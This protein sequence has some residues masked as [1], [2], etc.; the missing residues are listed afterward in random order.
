[1]KNFFVL[2]FSAIVLLSMASCEKVIDVDLNEDNPLLVIE[3]GLTGRETTDTIKLSYTGSYFGDD[4]FSPVQGAAVTISDDLG[5]SEQLKEVRPG[6]YASENLKGRPG[7]TYHLT[8]HANSKTYTASAKMLEPVAI[9]RLIYRYKDRSLG[10]REG[11]YVTLFFNDPAVTHNY[12]LVKAKGT[13]VSYNNGSDQFFVFDDALFNG[14]SAAVELPFIHFGPGVAEVELFSIDKQAFLY[15]TSLNEIIQNPGP[16]P[17]SGVPQNSAK[18]NIQ[19]EAVGYF[20]AFSV[21]KA[22]IKVF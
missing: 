17:F 12:Y 9:N 18:S 4:N 8:V 21:S 3:G 5:K 14:E 13:Q 7:G 11:N 6:S 10:T 15:Y 22:A 2:T 20:Q 1:M 16:S 19:G